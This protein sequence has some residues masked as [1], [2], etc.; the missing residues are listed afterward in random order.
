MHPIR[1]FLE[2]DLSF[3][4]IPEVAQDLPFMA[5][6]KAARQKGTSWSD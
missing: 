5:S 6:G 1:L 4:I 2:G 3:F